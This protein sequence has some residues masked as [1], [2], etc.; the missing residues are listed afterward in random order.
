MKRR[1]NAMDAMRATTAAISAAMLAA[2]AETE[3]QNRYTPEEEANREIA[4]A[5]YE[6][7]LN[8]KDWDKASQYLGDVY[9][10]HNPAAPDGPEGIRA[11]VAMLAERFP[12]NRGEIKHIYVDG[13]IVVL[14]VHSK[15]TPDSLGNAIVDIFRIEDGKVVEHW[16]VV[17]PVPEQAMNDNTMW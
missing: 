5:F 9:I 7:A 4:L 17:Q 6:A 13:D 2:C 1:R 14:H 3:A 8:E 15:R 12:Q 10:Q 11:H 16:D